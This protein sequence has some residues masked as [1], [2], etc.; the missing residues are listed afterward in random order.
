MC[1]KTSNYILQNDSFFPV[2]RLLIPQLDRERGAYGVKEHTLAK[3]YIQI[4]SLPKDGGD[5]KKL[6]EYRFVR[7]Q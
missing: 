6:L 5:A 3:I 2:L 7:K 4:L 1:S